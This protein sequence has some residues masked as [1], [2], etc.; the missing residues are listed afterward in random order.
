MCFDQGNYEAVVKLC[1]A[2]PGNDAFTR[3]AR[4]NRVEQASLSDARGLFNSGDYSFT[5][6]L[7]RQ[8]YGCKT[9]FVELFN[10]AM[11]EWEILGDLE[12]LE[13]A[14]NWQAVL[15]KLAD[16][17]FAGLTNKPPFRALAQWAKPLAVQAE[18]HR[19]LA[20]LN[21]TFETMLVRFNIK[22][23]TDSYVQTP[24]ARKEKKIDGGIDKTQR[25]KYLKMLDQLENGYKI[26]GWLNQNRRAKYIEKLREAIIHH[27]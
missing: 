13:R 20:Q 19:E 25:D 24:E 15:G 3:L 17:A 11:K 12:A 9:P 7:K 18:N 5:V 14:T 2:Y 23:P 8:P 26:G 6:R 16:P 1:N 27:E 4:S 21:V 22:S 10:Q